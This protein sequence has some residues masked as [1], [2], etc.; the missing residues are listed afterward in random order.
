MTNQAK[1][2]DDFINYIFA[3]EPTFLEKCLKCEFMEVDKDVGDMLCGADKFRTCQ[4][5]EIECIQE[6]IEC[7]MI[8]EIKQ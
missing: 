8:R 2:E 5:I 4:S 6:G 3:T 7:Q 1:Q